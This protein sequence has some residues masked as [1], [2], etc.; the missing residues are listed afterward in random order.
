MLDPAV[1]GLMESGLGHDFSRVRVH[2][3]GEASASARAVGA[4]VYTVGTHVAFA[5]GKY[6][7]ESVAGQRP[8]AHELVH[9][10]QQASSGGPQR[11]QRADAEGSSSAPASAADPAI[12]ALDLTPTAKA[13]AEALKKKHPG[14]K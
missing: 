11:L 5:D 1:R 14:I 8:L 2:T 7:P 4:H 12:D 3:D 6:A 10:V 13:A 9:V